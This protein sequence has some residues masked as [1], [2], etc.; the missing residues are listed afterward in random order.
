M[1]LAVLAAGGRNEWVQLHDAGRRV[2]TTFKLKNEICA[3]ELRKLM[4][5]WSK[6]LYMQTSLY[7][8][9]STRKTTLK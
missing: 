7:T 1:P 2:Q 9:L 5:L 8:K 3:R 4:T 6:L